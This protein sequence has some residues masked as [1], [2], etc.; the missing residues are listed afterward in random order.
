MMLIASAVFNVWNA[1]FLLRDAT[2][3]K[4]EQQVTLGLLEIK[5]RK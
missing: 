5:S 2:K 1:G 3:A 4:T